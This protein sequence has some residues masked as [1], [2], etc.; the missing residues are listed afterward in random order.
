MQ[1]SLLISSRPVARPE[2]SVSLP[3]VGLI[4]ASSS[5]GE[6]NRVVRIPRTEQADGDFSQPTTSYGGE[7][8]VYPEVIGRSLEHLRMSDDHCSVLLR[9][10]AGTVVHPDKLDDLGSRSNVSAPMTPNLCALALMQS[11]DVGQP[12]RLRNK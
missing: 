5:V 10:I 8:R 1:K 11:V 2:F 4:D 12:F 3:D 6:K 7:R 9:L